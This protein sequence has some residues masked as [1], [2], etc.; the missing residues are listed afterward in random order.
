MNWRRDFYFYKNKHK[1]KY[2]RE[3]RSDPTKALPITDVQNDQLCS[4]FQSV[5]AGAVI[6]SCRDDKNFSIQ[7]WLIFPEFKLLS[8]TLFL[9]NGEQPLLFSSV[10]F[11]TVITAKHNN[12]TRFAWTVDKS[13]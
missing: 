7:G 9:W 4:R 1:G 11:S 3:R 6:D 8:V 12:I 5:Y 10:W 13:C 2:L